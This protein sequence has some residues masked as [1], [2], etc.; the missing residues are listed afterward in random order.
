MATPNYTSEQI[1]ALRALRARLRSAK[2]DWEV[3]QLL[4]NTATATGLRQLQLVEWQDGDDNRKNLL[5]CLVDERLESKCPR[6]RRYMMFMSYTFLVLS[7]GRELPKPC[8]GSGSGGRNGST[9]DVHAT[10]EHQQ[11]NRSSNNDHP[12]I[13][14]PQRIRPA[15]TH[16]PL[17]R[18]QML[19]RDWFSRRFR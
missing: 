1:A 14:V 13:L 4:K 6:S 8:F 10:N 7:L 16:A 17:P 11:T 15:P 18:S 2:Y 3:R 5:H 19:H 12:R 9:I